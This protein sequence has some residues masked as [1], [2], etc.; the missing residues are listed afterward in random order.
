MVILVRSN[1]DS[2]YKRCSSKDEVIDFLYSFASCSEIHA[3]SCFID[4]LSNSSFA[5]SGDFMNTSRFFVFC[6]DLQ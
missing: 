6:E 5:S 1:F 4:F 2:Y 3:I